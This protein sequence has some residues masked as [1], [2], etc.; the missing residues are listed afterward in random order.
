MLHHHTRRRRPAFTLVE[1]LVV[2]AII[3]VLV[4]LLLPAIQAAREAARR[5]SCTNNMKQLGLAMLNFHDTKRHL[6][7]AT[8]PAG[9][10]T[11]PRLGVFTQLLPFFEEQNIYNQYDLTVNWSKPTAVAPKAVSNADLAKTQVPVF[12]CPSVPDG[13]EDRLDGDSQYPLQAYPDWTSSRC[14]APCD[15]SVIFGVSTRLVNATDAS[16]Q[17][18]IDQ[19]NTTT[20]LKRLDGLMPK[21]AKPQLRECTDGTANTIMLAECAGRPYVYRSGGQRVGQLPSNRVNGGGWIRAATD[22][23]LE[24][25]DPTLSKTPGACAI[26]CTNGEDVSVISGNP[27]PQVPY[28]NYSS[29]GTGETFA[30]HSGGANIL[31]ADGSV[32]FLAETTDIRMFARF[33]TRQ[34]EEI[35]QKTDF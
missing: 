11:L 8:R 26:N 15:Y 32:H 28:P 29:D 5:T 10:S 9:N 24:G 22:F 23:G 33:V 19:V 13:P 18:I 20:Q 4:A 14:A 31:F 35:V 7:S 6:P 25:W 21:N 16:M 27:D 2:I 12:V 1:L 17:P 34:G 3:G 30:F